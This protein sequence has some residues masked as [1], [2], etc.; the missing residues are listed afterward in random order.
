MP[1]RSRPLSPAHRTHKPQAHNKI[2]IIITARKYLFINDP[3]SQAYGAIPKD[4]V[5]SPEQ[6]A[7]IS[8]YLTISPA[9]N[10]PKVK[11]ANT[12]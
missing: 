10:H 5:Y 2:R 9:M 3:E 12:D 6:I 4:S 7:P 8:L 11:H 1:L